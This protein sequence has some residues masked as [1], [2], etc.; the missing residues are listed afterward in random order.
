M[1]TLMDTN[2]MRSALEIIMTSTES[3]PVGKMTAMLMF[4]RAWLNHSQSNGLKN[5]IFSTLADVLKAIRLSEASEASETSEASEAS[6]ASETSE[7][8]ETSPEISWFEGLMDTLIGGFA[9]ICFDGI[10]LCERCWPCRLLN[11]RL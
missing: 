11:P 6:E 3:T 7:T 5:R 2:V 1:S 10:T 4:N 8:S 9:N